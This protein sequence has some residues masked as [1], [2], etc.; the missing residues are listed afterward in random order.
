MMESERTTSIQ[1]LLKTSE[2][3][4]IYEEVRAVIKDPKFA[5]SVVAKMDACKR[6]GPLW[7]PLTGKMQSGALSQNLPD[8]EAT[9]EDYDKEDIYVDFEKIYHK[10]TNW[11]CRLCVL[12]IML[13]FALRMPQ[14]TYWEDLRRILIHLLCSKILLVKENLESWLLTIYCDV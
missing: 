9:P 6:S 1:P 14:M 10:V 5:I 12:V 7:D 2:E 11:C 4:D 8:R 3:V 13:L